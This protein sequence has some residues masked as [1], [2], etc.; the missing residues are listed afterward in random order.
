MWLQ[1]RLNAGSEFTRNLT[2]SAGKAEQAH[3]DWAT[4]LT[5]WARETGRYEKGKS[6]I[7]YIGSN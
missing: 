1:F 6:G 4:V 3:L 2:R 7:M 5:V